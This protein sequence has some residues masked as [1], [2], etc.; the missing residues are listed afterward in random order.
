MLPLKVISLERTPERRAEFG[1]RNRHLAYEFVNAVDG[2]ALGPE[3]IAGS[4]LFQAGLPYQAGAFGA[5]L[6]HHSLWHQAV[7][8][9]RALTV[10]EDDA[11]FRLDFAQTHAELLSG[12]APDWDIVLWGWNLDSILAM[13]M[14]PGVTSTMYFEY[15]GLLEKID[16]FQ[17]GTGRPRLY[18][19]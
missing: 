18:R 12:L 7:Q 14:M 5:A 9:G 8:T 11:I 1:R 17:S 6:S 16:E 19:L 13:Q 15:L 10:A 4:G 3:T 2:L